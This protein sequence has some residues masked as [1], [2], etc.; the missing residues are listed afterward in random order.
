MKLLKLTK[1]D[2]IIFL[3]EKGPDSRPLIELGELKENNI[4]TYD[5]IHTYL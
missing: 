2:M 4:P 1:V 3:I 5:F